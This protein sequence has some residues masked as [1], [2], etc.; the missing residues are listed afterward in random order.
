MKD[1]S[2]RKT[3]LFLLLLV[4]SAGMFAQSNAKPK[5]TLDTSDCL[6][7]TGKLDASMKSAEGEYTVKL[8]RDNKV[9]E[10]Q[11]IGVK[12]SFKF[13]LKKNMFY[14]IKVEKDGFIPRLFS[15]NTNIDYSIDVG[16]LFKFNFETNMI[17]AE[18]Y[19]QFDDDD[20]DFPLALISY[21]KS[22]DCFQY[23]KKYTEKIMTRIINQLLYGA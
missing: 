21:D 4:S 2:A 18:L 1:L 22:C 12:R 23:D 15:V 16:N 11:T 17:S 3:I 10:S 14:T 7:F 5:R 6:S 20:M 9:I 13:I 19:H 8:I